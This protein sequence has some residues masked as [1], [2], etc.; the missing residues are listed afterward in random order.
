MICH[1]PRVEVAHIG[2]GG[3]GTKVSD[4]LTLPL[5][6]QHHRL[7]KDSYHSVGNIETFQN[8]HNINLNLKIAEYLAYYILMEWEN[9]FDME[10][11]IVGKLIEKIEEHSGKD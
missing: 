6:A 11:F 4:Y 2:T 10:K 8:I 9:D 1:N 3:M 5:C 7:G